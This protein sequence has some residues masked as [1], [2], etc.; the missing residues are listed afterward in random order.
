MIKYIRIKS[1]EDTMKDET[2]SL[3]VYFVAAI[4][5]GYASFAVRDNLLALALAIAVF[6]VS[7]I[8][9]KNFLKKQVKWLLSNGGYL[10]FF[11]WFITWVILYNL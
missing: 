8:L 4:L 6:F 2:K 1:K 7:S 9:V 5:A 10:Y 11:I 3:L